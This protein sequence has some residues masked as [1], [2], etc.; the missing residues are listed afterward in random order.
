MT[1]NLQSVLKSSLH[2][3]SLHSLISEEKNRIHKANY[4][5]S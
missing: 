1:K 2:V 5:L 4:L 3:P